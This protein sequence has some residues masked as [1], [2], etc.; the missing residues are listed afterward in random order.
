MS[1]GF[2]EDVMVMEMNASQMISWKQ[3][4]KQYLG[5]YRDA[6]FSVPKKEEEKEFNPE[7]A[8]MPARTEA[9]D[10]SEKADLIGQEGD[11]KPGR[12]EPKEE[13]QPGQQ[14]VQTYSYDANVA[15]NS[16]AGGYEWKA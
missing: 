4:Q 3:V 16:G 13:T 5:Y 10:K 12:P 14:T 11:V 1:P 7:V 9:G 8:K 6:E 15:D 2:K